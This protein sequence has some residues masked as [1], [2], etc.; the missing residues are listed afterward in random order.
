MNYL[1]IIAMTFIVMALAGFWW[2]IATY[3]VLWLLTGIVMSYLR[4]SKEQ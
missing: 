4:I 2:G 3:L 1:L